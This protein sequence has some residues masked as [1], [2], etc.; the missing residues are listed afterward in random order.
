MYKTPTFVICFSFVQSR[1]SF[2]QFHLSHFS[3]VQTEIQKPDRLSYSKN[4]RWIEEP[5]LNSVVTFL[6]DHMQ[7]QSNSTFWLSVSF[8]EPTG[9]EK[10]FKN[11]MNVWKIF[12]FQIARIGLTQTPAW[13]R[14]KTCLCMLHFGLSWERLKLSFPC[15]EK[16]NATSWRHKQFCNKIFAVHQSLALNWQCFQDTSYIPIRLCCINHICTQ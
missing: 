1:N 16:G 4:S 5:V 9:K 12:L 3:I 6:P 2:I 14:G 7:Q 8:P 10:H 15:D 13:G 11:K